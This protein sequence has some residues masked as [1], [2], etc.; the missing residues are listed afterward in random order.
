MPYICYDQQGPG[1]N[2]PPAPQ[3]HPQRRTAEATSRGPHVASQSARIA[4]VHGHSWFQLARLRSTTPSQT[5]FPS[6]LEALNRAVRD[7]RR[8]FGGAF[9]LNGLWIEMPAMDC[10]LFRSSDRTRRAPAR[11]ATATMSASQ[12]PMRA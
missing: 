10:P 7:Q 11:T 1:R 2:H 6:T 4:S 9:S 3:P 12:N 8:G 5:V